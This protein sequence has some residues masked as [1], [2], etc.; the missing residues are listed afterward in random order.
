MN[1]D[2]GL[3]NPEERSSLAKQIAAAESLDDLKRVLE[4]VKG[5]EV[6]EQAK[7]SLVFRVYYR[8]KQMC[9]RDPGTAHRL[10]VDGLLDWCCEKP[11]DQL[12][13]S[14]KQSHE[15]RDLLKN[16]LYQYE[17]DDYSPIRKAILGRLYEKLDNQPCSEQM[18]LA[19]AIGFRANEIVER[20]EKHLWD[21]D[22]DLAELRCLCSL[23][24]AF[25][26]KNGAKSSSWWKPD[27]LRGR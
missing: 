5:K 22:K 23:G 15:F 13:I 2:S 1:N 4:S 3:S 21:S 16:W 8:M 14:K 26:P 7:A 27:C 17:F 6:F 24:L 9:S 10:I 18:W 19:A 25:H 12:A 11:G 20:L